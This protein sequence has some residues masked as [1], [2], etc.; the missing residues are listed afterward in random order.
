MYVNTALKKMKEGK[1]A[2]GS[3][4]GTCSPLAA[5]MMA[6]AGPDFVCVDNQHGLW[7]P[8]EMMAAFRAIH[9]AG[10]VPMARVLKNDFGQMGEI[11]DRGAMGIIV[12]MVNNV[13]DAKAA[14]FAMR[15]PPRGG[16]S[17]GW[18]GCGVYGPDYFD[19]INDQV[20]LAVQIETQEAIDNVEA[21]MSV[22]GVDGCWMGPGDLSFSMGVPKWSPKHNAAIKK[23]LDTCKKLGKIPGIAFGDMPQ[24]IKDGFQFVT[25][26]D[27]FSALRNTSE[28]TLKALRAL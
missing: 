26:I 17:G 16:R 1:P 4:C 5:E 18:Y 27:D 6:L 20:F 3:I 25:P 14:A 23:T 10:S 11:L 21:I 7:Q 15:F 28:A 22:D 12:P 13:A 8:Q 9:C 24:L 2:I 19:W